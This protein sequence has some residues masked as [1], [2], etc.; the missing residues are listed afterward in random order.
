MNHT[1]NTTPAFAVGGSYQAPINVR[2]ESRELIYKFIDSERDYQDWKWNDATCRSGGRHSR[3]EWLV[4]MRDYI[5][6]AMHVV[7]READ[8]H[9]DHRVDATM[10][11]IAAMAVACMEHNGGHPRTSSTT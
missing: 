6:E 1:P 2:P 9:C 8:Q 11:K 7:S 5:E 10:R 3:T 4:F